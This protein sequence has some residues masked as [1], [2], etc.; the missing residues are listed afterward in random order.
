MQSLA[1]VEPGQEMLAPIARHLRSDIECDRR[2][3]QA[4]TR[5]RKSANEHATAQR[6]LA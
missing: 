2:A 1:L 5:A 6:V 3:D 4:A